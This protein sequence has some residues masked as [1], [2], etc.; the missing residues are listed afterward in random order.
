MLGSRGLSWGHPWKKGS[1]RRRLRPAAGEED[2][3][4]EGGEGDDEQRGR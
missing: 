4:G 3:F 1:K 2:V